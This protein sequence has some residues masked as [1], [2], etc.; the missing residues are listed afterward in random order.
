MNKQVYL[1]ACS[2]LC[3]SFAKANV[4]NVTPKYMD[5]VIRAYRALSEDDK[6]NKVKTIC[7]LNEKVQAALSSIGD[8]KSVMIPLDAQ[9]NVFIGL[10]A[11]E[12]TEFSQKFQEVYSTELKACTK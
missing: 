10:E 3:F 12:A 1:I 5:G 11:A 6:N 8:K 2:F 9:A 7:D 4:A